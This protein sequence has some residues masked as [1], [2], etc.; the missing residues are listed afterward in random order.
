MNTQ[1]LK[2]FIRIAE[3]K[4]IT[5][6]A[7]QIYISQPSLSNQLKAL[8][9]ELGVTLVIRMS[10]HLELTD[11]GEA[12]YRYAKRMV[13]AEQELM[14]TI[15]SEANAMGGTLKVGVFP[16]ADLFLPSPSIRDFMDRY[17]HI[18]LELH[19][20]E[21]HILLTLLESKVIDLALV[22]L[23]VAHSEGIETVREPAEESVIAV[24]ST[25]FD[26]PHVSFGDLCRLPL[27]VS[28]R[29]ETMLGNEAVRLGQNLRVRLSATNIRTTL[30]LASQGI[31]VAIVPQIYQ[32][33]AEEQGLYC[34][35]VEGLE[36]IRP[37]TGI[38]KRRAE[39]LPPLGA[40]WI[41][42]M[43]LAMRQARDPL[44]GDEISSSADR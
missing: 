2:N 43:D 3:T 8:E 1:A 27:L 41:E 9:K 14:G 6:A 17:P 33:Y 44:G 4:N 25:P 7:K 38:L 29:M 36:H 22:R 24:S 35:A 12:L 23:P 16:S 34:R 42:A 40:E 13:E 32:K 28:R 15:R 10:R 31:G 18:Q 26:S 5:L 39:P 30:S 11:A 37:R 21:A 20:A 19:E